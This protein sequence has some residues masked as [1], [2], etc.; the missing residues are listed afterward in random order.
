MQSFAH[1]EYGQCMNAAKLDSGRGQLCV[2]LQTWDIAY[3][4]L[5]P[6]SALSEKAACNR[7]KLLRWAQLCWP[8]S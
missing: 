8:S 1:G 3:S 2:S 6:A 7:N 5:D 4:H